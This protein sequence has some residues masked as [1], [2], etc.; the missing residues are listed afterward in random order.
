MLRAVQT[1]AGGWNLEH[2][3][4]AYRRVARLM[5]RSIEVALLFAIA[6]L[7]FGLALI[8]LF[9]REAIAWGYETTA[10]VVMAV[11]VYFAVGLSVRRWAR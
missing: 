3:V 8:L 1:E 6:R 9:D 2:L 11:A 10:I 7:L 5:R 4:G